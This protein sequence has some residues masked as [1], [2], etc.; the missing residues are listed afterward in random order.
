MVVVADFDK[1][2][3]VP[4]QIGHDHYEVDRVVGAQ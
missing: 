2:T 1:L 3:P 4:L